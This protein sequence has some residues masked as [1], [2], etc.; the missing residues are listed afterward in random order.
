MAA[1]SGPSPLWLEPS[2]RNHPL[3]PAALA[4]GTHNKSLERTRPARAFG[5]IIVLPGRSAQ[6]LCASRRRNTSL[7]VGIRAMVELIRERIARKERPRPPTAKRLDSRGEAAL[8]GGTI[9]R[10]WLLPPQPRIYTPPISARATGV[11]YGRYLACKGP[12]AVGRSV[13]PTVQGWEW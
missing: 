3:R 1:A 5:S 10:S 11:I 2:P 12:P 6:P 8:K 4:W 13:R 9:C 7:S